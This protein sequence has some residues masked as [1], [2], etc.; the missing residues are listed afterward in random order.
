MRGIAESCCGEGSLQLADASEGPAS[1]RPA[2][3]AGDE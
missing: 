1:A 3:L 2:E